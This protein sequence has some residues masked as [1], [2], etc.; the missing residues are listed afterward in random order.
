VGAPDLDRSDD[1]LHHDSQATNAFTT[2]ARAP[3]TR[4]R[5]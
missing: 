2:F 4:R 5:R 3:R 1:A